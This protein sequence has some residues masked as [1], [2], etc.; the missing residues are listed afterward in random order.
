M[1]LAVARNR[2]FHSSSIHFQKA[3]MCTADVS[4]VF[5]YVLIVWN[6]LQ[7]KKMFDS[8]KEDDFYV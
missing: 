8:E 3:S 2:L 6:D 5:K 1:K 7:G 4:N